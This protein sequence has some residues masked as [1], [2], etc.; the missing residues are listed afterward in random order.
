L[1]YS[2]T[3]SLTTTAVRVLGHV[4][5]FGLQATAEGLMLGLRR[6]AAASGFGHTVLRGTGFESGAL[7]I[8]HL[9]RAVVALA[10]EVTALT[11]LTAEV[12]LGE[13]H[14]SRGADQ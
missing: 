5:T 10:T 13:G 1:P 7:F 8:A 9:R 3:R 6:S 14:R 11:S 12:P 4:E 2:A